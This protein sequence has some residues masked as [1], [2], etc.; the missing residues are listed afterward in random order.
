MWT[1][2]VLPGF[3]C[4]WALSL[5]AP[6]QWHRRAHSVVQHHLELRGERGTSR[7]ERRQAGTT[8][9]RATK[10]NQGMWKH[11]WKGWCI[12]DFRYWLL[13][14]PTF[15]C[16]TSDSNANNSESETLTGLKKILPSPAL[17]LHL[18]ILPHFCTLF[19]QF[20][21]ILELIQPNLIN[22]AIVKSCTSHQHTASGLPHHLS[23]SLH[24]LNTYHWPAL[25]HL[26]SLNPAS[27]S[28]WTDNTA[29]IK[30]IIPW[31]TLSLGA[32]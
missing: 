24:C 17:H 5:H 15:Q 10:P 28:P 18:N 3:L 31:L 4:L 14:S 30:C 13:I 22:S 32:A 16:M 11:S 2:G 27:L 12:H 20:Q 26:A 7:Q 9:P 29:S 23:L 1:P 6:A 19:L 8:C 21:A 25:Q